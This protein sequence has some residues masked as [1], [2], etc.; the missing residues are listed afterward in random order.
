M[1]PYSLTGLDLRHV[2][3]SMLSYVDFVIRLCK[4]M[5]VGHNPGCVALPDLCHF[6]PLSVAFHSET[7]A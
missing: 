6:L 3:H 5:S 7:P 2:M 4:K 1:S